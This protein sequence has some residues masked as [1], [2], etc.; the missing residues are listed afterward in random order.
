MP[1]CYEIGSRKQWRPGRNAD[2]VRDVAGC[3]TEKADC[4]RFAGFARGSRMAVAYANLQVIDGTGKA[5][6]G[7]VVVNGEKIAEV[8][9]GPPPPLSDDIARHDLTG[10]SILP[11]LIDCHVHLRNDGDRKS[12]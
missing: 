10:C 3:L 8:G 5:F 2:S 12:T 11:G 6:Q 9:K 4:G 7:H 1:I